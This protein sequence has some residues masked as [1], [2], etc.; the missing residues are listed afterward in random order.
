[1]RRQGSED[2]MV[3]E[4]REIWQAWNGRRAIVDLMLHFCYSRL[5]RPARFR[6]RCTAD[7]VGFDVSSK[8]ALLDRHNTDDLGTT[9]PYASSHD[10]RSTR[11][12][13]DPTTQAPYASQ[14]EICSVYQEAIHKFHSRR[15]IVRFWGSLSSSSFQL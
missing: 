5:A 13:T 6:L 15:E 9:F 2:K 11:L 8:Y 1:M 4:L 7:G 3:H 12:L 10:E 14:A